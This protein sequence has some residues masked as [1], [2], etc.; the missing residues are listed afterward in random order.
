MR[1]SASHLGAAFERYVA[2]VEGEFAAEEGAIQV[3][4][5]NHLRELVGVGG[6]LPRQFAEPGADSYRRHLL[7]ADPAGRFTILSVVWR[8]GDGTPIHGHTA[9]G[10]VGVYEGR[11]RIAS[12]DYDGVRPPTLRS[13]DDC[14]P[15]AV[16]HVS[17]GTD[18]PHRVSNEAAAAAITIHTYGRD[19]RDDPAKINILLEDA[20]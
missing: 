20:A 15:G 6:W 3:R 12:Y 14:D 4:V 17:A 13:E 16:C 2:A 1:G 18:R 8:P 7:Y 5:A 19:L 11:V 9:W 10:A